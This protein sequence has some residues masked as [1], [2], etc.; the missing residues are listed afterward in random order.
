MSGKQKIR[1]VV[2]GAGAMANKVH[3]PALASF[4]DVEVAAVVELDERRLHETCDQFGIGAEARVLATAPSEYQRVIE[5]VRPAGVYAIGQPDVMYPVWVWCLEH[6]WPLY[7]EK[8][9]GLTMHQARSL[10]HLAE[11]NKLVTQ[12]SHQRR[13]APIMAQVRNR[14]IA[15]G[16]IVHGVVEFLKYAPPPTYGARD[17]MMDDGTH[18][19]DTA[20]WICGGEVVRVESAMRRIGT[21]DLNWL[22]ATLHFDNGSICFVVCDWMSGRRVFRV[23]MHVAGAYADVELEGEARIYEAGD[24]AGEVLTTQQAANHSE[25]F[26]FG[27]FSAK[28]REFIDSLQEGRD[29]CSSPFRDTVKTMEVCHT[30]LGQAQMAGVA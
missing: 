14:L 18:A 1:V 3:Y 9:M 12:V 7:I 27:G 2:I 20:R 25:N 28:S 19:V 30:I 4:D 6:G 10:A 23:Q 5:R 24:Y 13:S 15:R 29:L 16:P 21:P 26:V 8:P 17:K 11:Q 22:G